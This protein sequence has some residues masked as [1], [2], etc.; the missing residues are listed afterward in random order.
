MKSIKL[1]KKDYS[2]ALLTDTYPA[3][4]P[5]IFSNDGLYI[6]GHIVRK[7]VS[8]SK[9]KV[10]SDI[11]ITLINPE[12]N[13]SLNVAD[14]KREQLKQTTP[15][16]YKIIKNDVS[17]RTLS[18]IHP[19]S[20]INYSNIYREHS[21]Y[22][23]SLCDK[24]DFSIR[25]PMKVCNSFYIKGEEQVTGNAY[26]E[27][28]IETI[29]E[30]IYKKHAS[31]Y[32]SYKGFN[33]IHKLYSSPLYKE[34][35]SKFPFMFFLDV[36][37]CFDSIYTHTIAWAAKDK[38]YIKDNYVNWSN[39]FAQKLD[40]TMQRSNANET[41][42]IPIG[43]EFSRIFAEVIFQR[44]DINIEKTLKSEYSYVNR[45]DY[46]VLRYVDDYIVFGMTDEI[47]TVVSN[48]IS[49]CLSEYNL[50]INSEKVTKLERPFCTDKSKIIISMSK[51]LDYFE[52]TIF[53][54]E[55]ISSRKYFPSQIYKK[56][57][58][59]N[60]FMNEVRL[61][62]LTSNKNGYSEVSSYLVSFFSKR[63]EAAMNCYSEYIEQGGKAGIFIANIEIMIELM[64]FYYKVHPTVNAS[65]KIA[66]V[67]VSLM[68]FLK[69]NQS[70][71][72]FEPQIK[73]LITSSI[74]DFTFDRNKNGK[75][76][77]YLSIERLNIILST[78]DF[79]DCFRLPESYFVDLVQTSCKLNYFEVIS[80]LYY[81]KNHQEYL[82]I[83]SQ[84]VGFAIEK[85]SSFEKIENDSESVHMLLDLI[86][87]PYL[88]EPQRVKLLSIV[89]DGIAAPKPSEQC[90]R[91]YLEA[92]DS[93][94]WFVNW[95]NLNIKQLIE[96]NE[97]KSQY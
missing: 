96:R 4:V 58:F 33:R 91:S 37:N 93:V 12:L 34:L 75:R 55:H 36:A 62:A 71:S 19:R 66:K 94:Y 11:Y 3:D 50:Y 10:V 32:F 78:S 89:Y 5:I 60:K 74:I 92:I 43:S 73:L 2:R 88:S 35:E 8:D 87:C 45:V 41:N 97:L 54:K 6:N 27:I 76:K 77:G 51:C 56:H 25:S 95:K 68:D 47:C 28:K 69:S 52:S 9:T 65:N 67:I 48:T 42:G 46:Q 80:L 7:L 82:D 22:L 38:D 83:Q 59:M 57:N 85:L 61:V 31:S 84:V 1:D 26:K 18:L 13:N 86:A 63:I 15:F 44:I 70:L 72:T 64:L 20:Q 30:E 29:E 81:F 23:V 16:K 24:S 39:Q 40:T 21:D 79:G 49:D 14:R 53:S 17:L 90:L